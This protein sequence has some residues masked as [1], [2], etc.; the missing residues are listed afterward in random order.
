MEQLFLTRDRTED[1]LGWAA[2][3]ECLGN[4]I[5][6]L[7]ESKDG[8]LALQYN[9]GAL[10][11]IIMDYAHALKETIRESYPA[12]SKTIDSF[13]WSNIGAIERSS[14]TAIFQ[15]NSQ[16]IKQNLQAINEVKEKFKHLYALEEVL[17]KEL[18]STAI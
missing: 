15:R 11:N 2:K 1:L 13:D 17:K 10:G 8:D 5:A 14:K 12:I 16:G 4:I 9:D 18:E 6:F 3:L 7:G